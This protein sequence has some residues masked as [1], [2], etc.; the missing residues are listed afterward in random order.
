LAGRRQA[1]EDFDRLNDGLY[2]ASYRAQ[3]ISGIIFPP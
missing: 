2:D 3:F 1:I